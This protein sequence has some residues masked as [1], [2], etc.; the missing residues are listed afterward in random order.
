MTPA[1]KVRALQLVGEIRTMVRA[2]RES[3]PVMVLQPISDALSEL[4]RVIEGEPLVEVAQS[5]RKGWTDYVMEPDDEEENLTEE[6]RRARN[7]DIDP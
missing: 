1:G 3:A 4:V 5:A 6:Q 2:E 7:L